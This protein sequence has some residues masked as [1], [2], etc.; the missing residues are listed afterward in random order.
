MY[1]GQGPISLHQLSLILAAD[2][3][4]CLFKDPDHLRYLLDCLNVTT[5]SKQLTDSVLVTFYPGIQHFLVH[6]AAPLDVI[7]PKC[8]QTI[9]SKSKI[10]FFPLLLLSLTVI[11]FPQRI[12]KANLKQPDVFLLDNL[13]E[14]LEE[15]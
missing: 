14:L 10:A 11:E 2:Y 8:L 9:L 15:E 1:F 4:L 12:Q 6:F 13:F 5:S 3:A 7:A